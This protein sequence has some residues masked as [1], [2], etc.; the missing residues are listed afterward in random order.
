MLAADILERDA[1]LS[2]DLR[3]RGFDDVMVACCGLC[4]QKRVGEEVEHLSSGGAHD[5]EFK[6]ACLGILRHEVRLVLQEGKVHVNG[7]RIE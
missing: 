6:D 3:V 4:L 5:V 2:D 1:L 7:F